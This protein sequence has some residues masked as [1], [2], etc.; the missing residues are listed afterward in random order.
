MKNKKLTKTMIYAIIV[1]VIAVMAQWI[2][3]TTGITRA[4]HQWW[5]NWSGIN[6]VG[7][8]EYMH[9]SML[10]HVCAWLMFVCG[11]VYVGAFVN[12][13]CEERT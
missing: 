1:F 7:V 12:D 3:D 5:A 6:F 10:Y 4:Y 2:L 9:S 13:V 11:S 8:M